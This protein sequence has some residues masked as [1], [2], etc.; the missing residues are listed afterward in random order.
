MGGICAMNVTR[1]RPE[2]M[3]ALI[4]IWTLSFALCSTD[5]LA[6]LAVPKHT[7]WAESNYSIRAESYDGFD[8]PVGALAQ[9][10]CSTN[11]SAT[12]PVDLGVKNGL[13]TN[14]FIAD[15]ARVVAPGILFGYTRELFTNETHYCTVRVI[16]PAQPYDGDGFSIP[17]P[18]VEGGLWIAQTESRPWE[19]RWLFH[20]SSNMWTFV[21]LDP[22]QDRDGDLLPDLWE[23]R[24]FNDPVIADPLE[25]TDKD[26]INNYNEFLAGMNPREAVMFYPDGGL[27]EY[28]TGDVV[29][30]A[31]TAQ[32]NVVYEVQVST[33]SV[34]SE[35]QYETIVS[36]IVSS[37]TTFFA[38]NVPQVRAASY[39]LIIKA[40]DP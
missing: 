39:R 36:N 9:F 16:V 13:L 15:V 24:Y 32:S 29:N 8:L 17:N 25:D 38:T 37:N 26:N 12:P 5:S 10:V 1:H 27:I 33:N 11:S 19:N 35:L 18:A 22:D 28:P 3:F 20:I 4:G 6:Q 14:W 21:P 2:F 31:W 7:I 23:W 34:G 30:I 40:S